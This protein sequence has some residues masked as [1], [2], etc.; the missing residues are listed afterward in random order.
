MTDMPAFF[1]QTGDARLSV[2]VPTAHQRTR[3]SYSTQRL[4]SEL[5]DHGVVKLGR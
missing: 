3:E 1:T 2:G 4:H 5:A